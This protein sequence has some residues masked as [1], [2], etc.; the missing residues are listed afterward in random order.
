MLVVDASEL[1]LEVDASICLFSSLSTEG[2]FSSIEVSGVSC[3]LEASLVGSQATIT[4]HQKK[5][6]LPFRNLS[7]M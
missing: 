6:G 3:S 1:D 2:Q 4:E 7:A 5:D